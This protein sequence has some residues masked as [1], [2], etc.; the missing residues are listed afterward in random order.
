[1][2]V[3]KYSFVFHA[4]P[5]LTLGISIFGPQPGLWHHEV[6][7]HLGPIAFVIEWEDH[8]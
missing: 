5:G 7:I 2:Q 6:I 3:G 8:K 1:M 4:W